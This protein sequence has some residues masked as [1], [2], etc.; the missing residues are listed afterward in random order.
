MTGISTP[1][2]IPTTPDAVTPGWLETALGRAYPGT[3][4]V[5]AEVSGFFGYKPNK[6]RV[7][8]DYA[9]GAATDLPR[10]LIVKGG[11]KKGSGG[12]SLTGLDIGLELEVLAYR[13]LVPHLDARTPRCLCV[14]FD[15]QRYDGIVLLEDL[16]PLGAVF[17]KD[18]AHLSREEAERFVEALARLHA[19]WLGSADLRDGGRFGPASPLAERTTRLYRDY[20]D[21][22]IEPTHWRGLLELPRGAAV[23]RLLQDVERIGHAWSR[24]KAILATCPLTIG[25][26]D[27]HIGNLWL[28]AHGEPGFIDWC[29]RREA[30]AVGFAYLLASTLDVLDRRAWEQDLL[31]RYLDALGRAGAPVPAWNDAWTWYRAAVLFPYLAWLNNSPKWQPESVNTRNAVRGAMAVVDLDTLGLLA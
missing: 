15:A 31:K 7:S 9:P 10:R 5:R 28:D 24:M 19:P 8:I 1:F 12:E 14:E 16:D 30:W 4:V 22:M 23:P 2:A 17:L 27:E 13:D 6:A 20:L 26:G 29:S 11:F 18:R 3:K 21:R 25:H